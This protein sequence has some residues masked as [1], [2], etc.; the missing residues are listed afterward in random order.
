MRVHEFPQ[1]SREAWEG[2]NISSEKR[3]HNLL[4]EVKS[5]KPGLELI[6]DHLPRMAIVRPC[7]T[8]G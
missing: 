3:L 8:R 5:L 2:Q 1:V 6:L 7:F 4:V